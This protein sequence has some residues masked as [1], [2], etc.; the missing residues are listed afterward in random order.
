M[1]HECKF[2]PPKWYTKG[3]NKWMTT[4]INRYTGPPPGKP[5]FKPDE[6]L[7]YIQ[8]QENPL[9]YKVYSTGVL[10]PCVKTIVFNSRN[11]NSNKDDGPDIEEIR[12][13]RMMRGGPNHTLRKLELIDD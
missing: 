6:Y 10:K 2:H 12:P 8:R 11:E 9:P 3:P 1:T 13:V 4:D 7:R 5:G